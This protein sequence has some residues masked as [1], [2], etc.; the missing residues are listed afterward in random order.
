MLTYILHIY[1]TSL[2]RVYYKFDIRIKVFAASLLLVCTIP[3][4]GSSRQAL[5]KAVRALHPRQVDDMG[6][7]PPE[8][9]TGLAVPVHAGGGGGLRHLRGQR[10]VQE[11]RGRHAEVGLQQGLS[12]PASSISEHKVPVSSSAEAICA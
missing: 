4:P 11:R 7:H 12:T 10:H 9:Y 6:G 1:L 2:H 5:T 8:D 3:A